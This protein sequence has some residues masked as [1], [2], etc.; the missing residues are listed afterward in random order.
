MAGAIGTEAQMV[1]ATT[2]HFKNSVR[3]VRVGKSLTDRSST[4]IPKWAKLTRGEGIMKHSLLNCRRFQLTLAGLLA[5]AMPMSAQ[6]TR[7]KTYL[8]AGEQLIKEH[9]YVEADNA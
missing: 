9:S 7:W 6:D 2:D 1:E 3:K 4:R 5:M 8:D